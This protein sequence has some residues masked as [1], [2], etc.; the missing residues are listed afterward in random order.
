VCVHVRVNCCRAKAGSLAVLPKASPQPSP[1][2]ARP[3][4]INASPLRSPPAVKP[5]AM[6]PVP[7]KPASAPRTL[8][9]VPDE[10]PIEVNS[11]SDSDIEMQPNINFK[12]DLEFLLDFIYKPPRIC[13]ERPRFDEAPQF[14]LAS[15]TNRMCSKRACCGFDLNLLHLLLARLVLLMFMLKCHLFMRCRIRNCVLRVVLFTFSM[16]FTRPQKV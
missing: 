4:N 14:N 3:S 10:A 7:S 5:A 15:F 16:M 9:V 6:L 1:V 11:D 13:K 12:G 2:S 8:V